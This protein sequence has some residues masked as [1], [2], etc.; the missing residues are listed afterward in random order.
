MGFQRYGLVFAG[1]LIIAVWSITVPV[2]AA[3]VTIDNTTP[4]GIATAISSAG[5]GGTVILNP[6]IFFENSIVLPNS[7]T[8]QANPAYGGN[9][10]NTII[11][12]MKSGRI[13]DAGSHSLTISSL[14]LRNGTADYGG[15]I[16]ATSGTITVTSSTIADCSADDGG[17]IWSSIFDRVSG[18][19]IVDSSTITGCRATAGRGGAIASISNGAVTITSSTITGCLAY[20]NGGAVSINT[21]PLTITSSTFSHCSAW[22]SGAVSAT[23]GPVAIT[24][25]TFSDCSASNNGGA[26]SATGGPLTITSSTFSRCSASR[27][28]GVYSTGSLTITYSTFTFCSSGY[29][30]GAV[31]ADGDTVTIASSTFENCSAGSQGGAIMSGA[32]VT[33]TDSTFTGCTAPQGGAIF[34][35]N[36]LAVISSTIAS[37][38]ATDTGSAVYSSGIDVAIHFSRIY[39]NTGTAVHVIRRFHAENTWWGTNNNPRTSGFVNLDTGYSP[40][41]VLGITATPSS[42]ST[43]QTSAVRADLRFNSDRADTSGSG[44]VP[45]N[46]QNTFAVTSG[47]GSVS[48]VTAG[49]ANGIAGTTFSPLYDGT[50][51]ISATVDDQIVYTTLPVGLDAPAPVLPTTTIPPVTPTHTPGNNDGFP[52]ATVSP[53]AT[54]QEA[55]P[56]MTVTVNI[57]GDSKAWQAVVTGTKLSELIVTGTEQHGL[58][59]NQTA[60]TGIVFQYISLVPARFN[61]ITKAVINFTVPQ[62]WLDESHIDPKNIVLYHQTANG[63]EALPTV[64]L[65]TKD[66]TVYYSAESAGFSLFA[67]AGTPTAATPAVTTVTTFGGTVQEEATT[68]AMITKA[69]VTTQTTAPPATPAAKPSAPSPLLNIVLAIAAIGVLAGGGFMARRWWVRRQNP[70]LFAEDD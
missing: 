62:A 29:R 46:I 12:A 26:I 35:T 38:S 5:E 53:A 36:T 17:A 65:S 48:P 66:G 50:T 18:N 68:R 55:V 42:I 45:D 41:L 34:S 3:V 59:D 20:G 6:G 4:G 70:A 8:I 67:I 57:G 23:T 1:L 33:V 54:V 39:H 27:G 10:D 2:S 31:L 16:R 32:S 63:W 14:T 22:N 51:T 44:H 61:T 13:V 25:S 58:A 11:D 24:S 52:S 37:C 15:A 21:G 47:S 28:S 56:L 40:W 69:T 64:V 30:G 9:R 49:T 43:S 60:P 19:I 7:V